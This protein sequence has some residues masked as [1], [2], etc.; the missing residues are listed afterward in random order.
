MKYPVVI[1]KGPTSYGA[2][3]PDLPGCGVAGSS[4]TE[5]MNL[6]QEAISMHLAGLKEQGLDI[7]N[8]SAIEF[9]DVAA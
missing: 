2:Y 7:P 5:V 9:V 1:E 3:V 4:R 6:I 8:P